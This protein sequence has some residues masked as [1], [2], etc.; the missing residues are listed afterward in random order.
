M[1]MWV[2]SFGNKKAKPKSAIFACKFW[3]S[4]ILLALMSRCMIHGWF[5]RR[6]HRLNS[7]P[8]IILNCIGHVN[9][10]FPFP[11]TKNAIMIH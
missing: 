1:G 11:S 5:S 8:R 9:M 6:Y 4:K 10:W 3:S 2:L 7:T